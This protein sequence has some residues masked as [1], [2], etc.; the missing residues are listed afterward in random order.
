MDKEI[1]KKVFKLLKDAQPKATEQGGINIHGDKNIIAGGDINIVR[2][3][4]IKNEIKYDPKKHISSKDAKAISDLIKR[5]V[6]AEES[7]GMPRSQAYAKWYGRLKNLFNVN[8]Y[9]EIP[10]ESA[11]YAIN[12]LK[13]QIAIER[14]KL[15]IRNRDEWK[16]QLYRA[17]Y[18]KCSEIGWC[19]ADLYQYVSNKLKRKI[20]GLK[21]LK[22]HE[23]EWLYEHMKSKK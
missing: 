18:A 7:A 16:K 19:K 5:L 4:V 12:W 8:S 23:L 1:N 6:K 11:D 3:Q 20:V 21:Q 17:I 13:Q 2:K 10:K 14:P 9:K 22:N 15:K